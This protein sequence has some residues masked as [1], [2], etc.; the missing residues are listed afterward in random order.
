MKY[1]LVILLILLILFFKPWNPQE[2]YSEIS[3]VDTISPEFIPIHDYI[4]NHNSDLAETKCL[5]QTIERFIKQW[6]IKGA[7]FAIMKDGKLVYSKGY[8][9]ADE[10][11]GIKTNV[12][13]IFRVA[14]ISKL[15][16]A[17][18]I[19][20]LVE[21]H[22]LRLSDPVFG[23]NGILPD[24]IY[25]P[26]A[27]KRTREITVE[28]LLRHRGGFTL[29][30]GDPMFLP[31]DIAR[32]MNIP[33]PADLNT[34]IRFVLS[35]RLHFRPGTSTSYS[36]VGYGILSKVIEKTSG[37]PYEIFIRDSILFPAGCYDMHLGR[38][39]REHRFSNE[40]CYYEPDN[41]ELVP[42]CNGA[43]TLVFRSNGGNNI[44]ELFGAGGWVA[45]P[46]EL[47]R[48]LAAI[49]GDPTKPDLLTPES[50]RIMTEKISNALPLGWMK[51][52]T[53]GDWYR[54]G[55]LAGTSAMMKHQRDGF[56]WVFITNTSSWTGAKFS[57]KIETMIHQAIDRVKSWPD[58]DLFDPSYCKEI[59]K[60]KQL[61]ANQSYEFPLPTSNTLG[62]QR[63]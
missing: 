24:S 43:D 4:Q 62:P 5:D 45:S 42:S 17:V 49:D 18:G 48:F 36:N 30:F 51:T 55:T 34:I 32:K 63:F 47:L 20:K 56:S 14:S 44:E 1:I 59:E 29:R 46:T 22:R 41:A 37:I 40:V 9:Y 23:E 57:H 28:H 58:R 35:K 6:E 12:N 3:S 2:V 19:M 61:L 10:E 21:N 11:Q 54:S 53:E 27:D 60:N 13:H 50:I 16:T 26:V 15:I 7:S 25:G 39:L 52:N 38:N 31:V 8:G 33:P